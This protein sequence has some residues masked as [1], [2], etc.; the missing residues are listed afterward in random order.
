MRD[1]E[2]C[3]ADTKYLFHIFEVVSL[4]GAEVFYHKDLPV[5]APGLPHVGKGARGERT[6]HF[7]GRYQGQ[8][9]RHAERSW[10]DPVDTTS[11]SQCSETTVVDF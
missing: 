5:F 7:A 3:M 8:F 6:F 9:L 10:Q 4:I 1:T 2:Y 11:L